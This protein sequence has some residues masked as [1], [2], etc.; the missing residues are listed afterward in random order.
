MSYDAV[1]VVVTLISV[2]EALEPYC[3][4]ADQEGKIPTWT[5]KIAFQQDAYRPL[6]D[7]TAHGRVSASGPGG[8]G[9][10]PRGVC[11]G[12]CVPGGVCLWSK[13]GVSQHALGQTLPC[14][15]NHRHV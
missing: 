14:E 13:G 15:Q 5:N 3:K 7:R 2:V 6:V 10:L 8:G 12:G 1:G 11:P 4:R 9:C